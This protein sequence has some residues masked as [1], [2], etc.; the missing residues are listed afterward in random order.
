MMS[1]PLPSLSEQGMSRMK[2][3]AP[4]PV[5][6]YP[7]GCKGQGG[8]G[9]RGPPVETAWEDQRSAATR[10]FQEHWSAYSDMK[11]MCHP[12]PAREAPPTQ[13]GPKEVRHIRM[14]EGDMGQYEVPHA[15]YGQCY[16]MV[17]VDAAGMHQ[18]AP[19][20]MGVP[21]GAAAPAGPPEAYPPA[22]PPVAPAQPHE[23]EMSWEE[24]QRQL[25]GAP[26][27]Q[28]PPDVQWAQYM[29]WQ[30]AQRMGGGDW[31][32][33]Q[34]NQESRNGGRGGPRPRGYQPMG[35]PNF[36][37]RFAPVA[38][39]SQGGPGLVS[40]FF[41]NVTR[42]KFTGKPANWWSFKK[43]WEQFI[44][45]GSCMFGQEPSDKILL[46]ALRECLD[47][48]NRLELGFAL[49]T[50]GRLRYQ[51]FWDQL[52]EKYERD[53]IQHSCRAWEQVTLNMREGEDLTWHAWRNFMAAY[54]MRA[55]RYPDRT[56]NEERSKILNDLPP[57]WRGEVI[58]EESRRRSHRLLC[59]V[60][61]MGLQQPQLMQLL[62]EMGLG[63]SQVWPN[64]N[65]FWVEIPDKERH[66][67]LLSCAGMEYQ[68]VI[69][70]GHAP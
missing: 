42:P 28:F 25:G 1:G 56:P 21:A 10:E 57:R 41:G 44:S 62:T 59:K 3:P 37:P 65:S 14:I 33:P 68:G 22:N 70:K 67:W 9:P 54:R 51:E 36:E 64:L 52:R 4:L 2:P 40:F 31:E 61:G 43:D 17:Q 53:A 16:A 32:V 23:G 27:I 13:E 19:H 15:H 7:Q 26:P 58:K 45:L 46:E 18:E 38:T 11:S 69:V 29:Q 50:R 6:A 48:T 55:M 63:H 30:D 39:L 35:D 12:I 24:Y 5:P 49:E 8:R 60:W 47:P 66:R 34:W 20:P